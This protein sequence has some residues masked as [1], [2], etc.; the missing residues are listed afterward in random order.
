MQ[1]PGLNLLNPQSALK[2]AETV[3]SEDSEL[4]SANAFAGTNTE[5][6]DAAT[7]GFSVSDNSEEGYDNAPEPGIDGTSDIPLMQREVQSAK[8]ENTSIEP[9]PDALDIALADSFCS[10]SPESGPSEPESENR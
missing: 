4:Q 2:V 10:S 7:S 1:I 8:E 3:G 9:V 6:Y 5:V